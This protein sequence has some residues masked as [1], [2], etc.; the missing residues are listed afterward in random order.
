MVDAPMLTIAPLGNGEASDEMIK[1][2]LC[3][4]SRGLGL[5]GLCCRVSDGR[6][7]IYDVEQ[8]KPVVFGPPITMGGSPWT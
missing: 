7:C 8:L 4:A 6:G 2:G 3:G 5:P 1:P